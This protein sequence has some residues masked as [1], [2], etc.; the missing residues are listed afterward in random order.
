MSLWYHQWSGSWLQSTMVYHPGPKV[1]VLVMLYNVF[2]TM[3]D[4]RGRGNIT[5]R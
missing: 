3:I 2:F 4:L 1:T 5:L